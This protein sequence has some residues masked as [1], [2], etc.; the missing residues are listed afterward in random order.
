MNSR[1][2]RQSLVVNCVGPRTAVGIEG[3]TGNTSNVSVA[4][5]VVKA[6]CASRAIAGVEEQKCDLTR[7]RGRFHLIHQRG[8]ETAPSM[9]RKHHDLLHLGA[10][11]PV[12]A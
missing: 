8:G 4:E 3:V 5:R 6:P 1:R 10:M 11:T 9:R 12:G 7:S 2:G